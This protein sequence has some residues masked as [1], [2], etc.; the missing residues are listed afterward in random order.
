MALLDRLERKLGRYAIPNV[1]L[2]LVFGQSLF[3]ALSM[4]SPEIVNR[5]TLVPADIQKGEWWRLFSWV[6]TPPLTNPIFAFFALYLFYLF[7]SALEGHWGTFRYNVYLLIAIL[8]T[9]GAAW[10]VPEGEATN[11]FIGGS[12]FLAFAFLYPDFELLLFFILPVKVKYLALATWLIYGYIFMV[13]GWQDRALIV[14]SVANFLLFFSKDLLRMARSGKRRMEA[15]SARF[16]DSDKPF[17]K[18]AVCGIT[19]KSH[20]QM[21]F[22][23]CPVC[24]GDYAYCTEHLY[25]HDH[26]V[27][28]PA[29]SGTAT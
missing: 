17:H 15:R 16:A 28:H 5:M 10:L 2:F 11:A 22:R 29:A 3:F 24:G 19:D 8:A 9:L 23:Y 6:L 27:R 14:A 1:T 13:G 20:P 4:A 25:N 7:G 18:C 12:V 26:K 21:D